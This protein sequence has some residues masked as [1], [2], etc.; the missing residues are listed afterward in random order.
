MSY[1]ITQTSKRGCELYVTTQSFGQLDKRFRENADYQ[2]FCDRYIKF[3]N[4]YYLIPKSE[5]RKLSQEINEKLHIL[6]V[7]YDN[8]ELDLTKPNKKVYLKAID[9][10]DLYDTTELI[11]FE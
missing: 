11:A 10:F 4:E 9:I 3:N 5:K 2:V 6:N 7:F 1:F 8:M